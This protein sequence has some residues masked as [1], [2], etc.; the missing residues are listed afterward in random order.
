MSKVKINAESCKACA[1][2]IREC[3]RGAIRMTERMNEKGYTVVEI[4]EGKCIKCGIC[5][6][7]CPDCVF[8][9]LEE[10]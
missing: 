4:D 5:Y 2:C 1:L 8:E 7:M 3:P 10:V 9:L 6:H